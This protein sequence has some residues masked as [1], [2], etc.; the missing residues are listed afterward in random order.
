MSSMV[1]LAIASAASAKRGM[2][3]FHP[4]WT[5]TSKIRGRYILIIS[6]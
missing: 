3:G 4:K 1:V 5:G 2:M 6:F